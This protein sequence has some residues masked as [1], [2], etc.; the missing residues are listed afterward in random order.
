MLCQDI[1]RRPVECARRGD[2]VQAVARRMR[3]QNIGFLPICDDRNHAIGVV[4]DR[5]LAI[6]LCADGAS[7]V[8]TRIEEVMTSEIVHCRPRDELAA[9]EKL[10]ASRH[11]SRILVTS[12]DGEPLGV[13]S[14]SDVAARSTDAAQVLREVAAREVLSTPTSPRRP[15]KR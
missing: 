5:D 11:K 3:D 4:T 7:P 10:M 8:E 14:L 6:R 12:T 13:I 2:T 9:A 1:M 15:A